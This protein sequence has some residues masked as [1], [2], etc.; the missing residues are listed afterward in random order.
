MA[1]TVI[2][3]SIVIDGEVSSEEALVVRGTVKGQISVSEAVE[4]E[5]GAVVEASIDAASLTVGGSVIGDITVSG[6]VEF[7]ADSNV[8]GDVR[9]PRVLI[10]EGA[11]FKGN[12]DM[13]G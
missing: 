10:A 12:I 6:R 13:E 7:Q 8:I 2:G 5:P 4:V 1:S 3:S 9:S 11:A